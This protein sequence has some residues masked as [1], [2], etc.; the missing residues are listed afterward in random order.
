M[1]KKAR[2][3]EPRVAEIIT[4]LPKS[5]SSEAAAPKAEPPPARR[6]SSGEVLG[7]L[8]SLGKGWD[9]ETEALLELPATLLRSSGEGAKY[10]SKEEGFGIGDVVLGLRYG[11]LGLPKTGYGIAIYDTSGSVY[12]VLV[13]M[14]RR[15]IVRERLYCIHDE[16][17]EK[18]WSSVRS[19]IRAASSLASGDAARK[20]GAIAISDG[21]LRTVPASALK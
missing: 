13:D 5:F 20:E 8:R 21:A 1:P 2:S 10:Y 4:P 14:R 3:G 16:P 17:P 18:D 9:K 7:E 19:A 11:N 15:I 6:I 12:F